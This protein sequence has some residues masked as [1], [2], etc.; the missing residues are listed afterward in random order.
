MQTASILINDRKFGMRALRM[1]HFWGDQVFEPLRVVSNDFRSLDNR[2]AFWVAKVLAKNDSNS[3]NELSLELYKRD[4][5]MPKLVGA[6]GLAA[7]GR[8]SNDEFQGHGYLHRILVNEEYLFRIDSNGRKSYSD[9]SP[10]EL[11]LIAAKH[12]RSTESVPDIIA[13]IEKRPL[14]YWVHANAAEA[15]GVIGDQRGVI[16]LETAMRAPDFYALPEAFLALVALSDNQ[17]I[18]LAIDRISPGIKGKNSGFVVSELEKMTGKNFGF[19]QARWRSW[20]E[21]KVSPMNPK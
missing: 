17:A 21:S 12:A 4:A 2:N 8:L 1:S 7:H 19:D 5:M 3:C 14:P 13:L 15:L 11:T 9:S 6:I 18:P 10:I 20:W 16:A